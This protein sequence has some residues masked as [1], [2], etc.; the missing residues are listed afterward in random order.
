MLDTIRMIAYRAETAM[1]KLLTGFKVDF[2]AGRR[3]MQD[4]FDS[5]AD[6]LPD[7]DGQRLKIRVHRSARPAT[8]RI[9]AEL[10]DRL[11]Q[12]EFIYPGTKLQ[13]VYEMHG[14]VHKSM[15]NVST[16]IPRDQDL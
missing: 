5:Q 8:D 10:L 9:L 11:N 15:E 16:E 2:T 6:I 7:F 1:V 12:T 4:L 14:P 13:L 3:L